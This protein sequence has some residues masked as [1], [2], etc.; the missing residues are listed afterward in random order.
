MRNFFYPFTFPYHP[1]ALR[2]F[3][4]AGIAAVHFMR[5]QHYL[6]GFLFILLCQNTVLAQTKFSATLS[7]DVMGKD[8]YC[9]LRILIENGDKITNITPPVFNDFSLVSG[10]QKEFGQSIVDNVI[11]RYVA[12]SYILKPK[13][14][15]VLRLSP[16]IAV[17]DGKKYTS[18]NLQVNVTKARAG[19][20]P[21]AAAPF[22]M[23]DPFAAEATPERYR[24]VILKKG[25]SIPEKVHQNMQMVLQTSKSSVYV[26]EPVVATY[27]LYTRLRH[28]TR[29]SRM[30]SFNGFSAVDMQQ[31]DVTAF[32]QAKLNGRDYNVYTI[33][34]A[35]LYPLQ[36]GEIAIEAAETDNT[37]YFLKE[38]AV[39]S[40]DDI[41]AFVDGFGVDPSAVVAQ[42]VTLSSKP[43]TIT[44][45]PLPLL[46]KP[47][48]FKGAVGSFYINA[49][50]EKDHFSTSE[51][52]KLTVVVSGSGNFPLVTVPEIKW[53]AGFDAFDAKL[54]EDI[55]TSTVPLSGRKI[56]EIPF[57]V[58]HAGK[59]NIPAIRFSY[60]DPETGSYQNLQTPPIPFEV[61]LGQGKPTFSADT[62]VRVPPA[63]FGSRLNANRHWVIGTLA[64]LILLGLILFLSR[65]NKAIAAEK[66]K[67]LIQVQQ[68]MEADEEVVPQSILQR[69]KPLQ[70]TADCL[71]SPDCSAFYTL[72]NQELKTFFAATFHLPLQEIT[73]ANIIGRMDKAGIDN[74]LTLTAQQLLKEIEWQLYTPMERNDALHDTF[75]RSQCLVEKI[76][77]A[78]PTL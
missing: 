62:I 66:K 74:S 26:G 37:V 52:G 40:S 75:A 76:K 46:H 3:T 56:F 34:K 50:L 32:N 38:E 63:S 72:L 67:K 35:Q 16:A 54:T 23:A 1:G 39:R 19:N 17:V 36:D 71:N 70:Q 10:P 33:R 73:T 6:L 31:P 2:F 20:K 28:E 49:R 53:P 58:Q 59:F 43:V 7:P 29:I 22:A 18:G 41:N 12:I 64:A 5:V 42:Q 4:F 14:I 55:R 9:V 60:F 51:A 57:T 8:E 13:H 69:E 47:V 45:K 11:S 65:E 27:Q 30:P 48:D 61:T 25:E 68:D 24:D 44:V 15:G 21:A 77:Q 78:A